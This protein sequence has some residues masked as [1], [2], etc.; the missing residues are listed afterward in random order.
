MQIVLLSRD[1]MLS[2]RLEG[3][4]RQQEYSVHVAA[5]VAGAI[6]A[7]AE[8]N[9]RL[10]FIDLQL[11]RL[12]IASLVEEVRQ[13]ASDDLRIVACGPHV[14]EQR[15]RAAREAGCDLVVTRGQ[16]DRE[17]DTILRS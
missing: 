5:E 3:A 10:L 17:A 1:L 12:D 8:E 6:T 13:N 11:P 9:C 16:F 7:V 15:L 14:H 2:S 4:A